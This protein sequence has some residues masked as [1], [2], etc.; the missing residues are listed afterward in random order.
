MNVVPAP[1]GT[2]DTLDDLARSFARHLRAENKSPRTVG[3]YLEAVTQLHGFLAGRDLPV[4]AGRIRR[5]H[6]ELFIGDLLERTK[7]ATA[8]NRYRGLQAFFKWLEEEE[9][10]RQSPMV[11][12]K[13]PKVPEVPVPVLQEA[14]LRALL[15]TCETGPSFRDRR[16][17]AIMRVFM[18]T[19]LRLAEMAGIRY[20]PGDDD[21]NDV[22]LDGG[23]L[24]VLGKG[25]RP[26]MVRVG[27]RAVKALDRYLR[28]R[29]RHPAAD[30]PWLWLGHKGQ[31]SGSGIAQMI[32]ERGH[33]AGLGRIH[34]HQLRHSFA[35]AWLAAGGEEGDLMRITGWRTRAMVQ[36]YA[37]STA[38]ERALAAHKRL[39]PG[40]RL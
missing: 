13:P 25:S 20:A 28:V 18:D 3:T 15:K 32:A 9:E 22:D 38:T 11:K 6:V 29:P 36:R 26:R 17:H 23:L 27:N 12:M 31:L 8:N 39:S 34:P 4:D 14:E 19:G 1:I 7:P 37:A 30:G 10:I 2:N 16:D 35:H 5:E 33:A 40:D 21:A 24:R